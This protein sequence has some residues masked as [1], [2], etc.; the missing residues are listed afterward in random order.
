MRYTDADGG[1]TATEFDRF[2]KPAKI[3]HSL[4]THQT[5]TY[6]RVAEPRGLVTSVTDSVGKPLTH[7][8][9]ALTTRPW[10]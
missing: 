4:G 1:W 5:F 6:D 10:G 7:Q 3:T 8:A 9:S 2:G